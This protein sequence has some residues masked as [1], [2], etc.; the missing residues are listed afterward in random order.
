MKREKAQHESCSYLQ[1]LKTF[2]IEHGPINIV[3]K[4]L[5]PFYRAHVTYYMHYGLYRRQQQQ[6]KLKQKK[7][8]AA[9]SNDQFHI[10]QC[11]NIVQFLF[12]DSF[13]FGSIS[14]L[15][16]VLLTLTHTRDQISECIKRISCYWL[17]FTRCSNE[18]KNL[19]CYSFAISPNST[20]AHAHTH[21][22]VFEMDGSVYRMH[23]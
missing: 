14:R 6:R 17:L 1:I 4:G 18:R 20:F 23:V 8:P 9:L 15:F 16:L 5:L 10:V 12:F 11:S 13:H 21:I 19:R 3:V 2:G 22:E 7:Q